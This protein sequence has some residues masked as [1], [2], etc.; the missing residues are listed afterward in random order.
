MMMKIL[1]RMFFVFTCILSITH[2]VPLDEFFPYGPTANDQMFPPNDDGSTDAL[3]L[4]RIFPYFNNNHRQIYLAN[5]G[6]FSFLGPVSQFVPTP[7]PLN[8]NRRVIAGFWSDIDTRGSIPSGNKVYYQIYANQSNTIVFGKATTYVQQ[9]FPG[10]RSFNPSMIITGTWYRVGAYSYQTN[11]ANTFQIVLATDE[12]RSFAFLLYHDLQWASPSTKSLLNVNSSSEIGG[13]AG[14]NAG[15][16][17][18]FEMLPYSRTSDV[19]RLVNIS[20]VNIPGLFVFRID[21]DTI[22]IGGCGNNSNLLFRPRRGSQLGFTPII[23]QG[24]CFTNTSKGDIKCRFG[25]SML[26]D[27]IVISEFQA[28]CLTPSVPLPTFINV[29]LSIDRGITYQLLPNTFTYTP[30]EYGLSSVDN[31]QVIILNRTDM[32]LTI[33][34]RLIL[35]WYLSET[36]MNNWPNNTI[37]FEIQMCI[38]TLN[39]SNGGITEGNS[40]VLQTNLTPTLGFQST[41]VIIS[42]IDNNQFSTV[43]FRIIARD[44]LTNTIYAGFNSEVIVLHDTN[45]DTSGYCQTWAQEQPLP[46]I[47]NENLLPCPLTIAQARVARCCYEPDPLCNENSY[48]S[49]INCNLHRGRSNRDELSAIAC[50]L[51]R[52]TNQWNAGTQCCYSS[53]GQLITHGTGAGTDNRYQPALS[54]IL[55]FFSDTLPFL[56]CCLLNSNE[57][58][59]T[60][61]FELRPP[62]R[63]SNSPNAWAGTWGDPHFTTLDGSAY[64]FNGYG[65]YIYLAITNVSTSIN[66]AFNPLIQTLIFNSQ[67]RTT[68]LSSFNDSATVIRG[69]AAKSNHSLAQRM[70]ITVSRRNILIIRRDNETLDLDTTNDDTIS[71]NN[72]IVLFFPEMT[73]ERNQTSGVLTLSWFIGV[74]IQ[75]TPIS[76]TDG[77]VLNIG[78]SV[79][80]LHQ[81]RTFGLLGLYDNNPNNDLRTPNGTIVGLPNTLT[82]QQIHQQFGQLWAIDPNDSLFYYEM[83]DSAINYANQNILYIPSFTLP[84]PSASQLNLTLSICNID[85]SLTNRSSWTTAQQTCFY[86]IAVTNDISL[87]RTSRIAAETVVQISIDQR[88]P[89]EFNSDLPLILIM[90]DSNSITINFTAVSPYTSYI[91]YNLIQGPSSASF[92]NQTALFYWEIPTLN[93]SETVIRVTAQDTQYQLLSTYELTIRVSNLD[94]DGGITQPSHGQITLISSIFI[95]MNI[96]MTFYFY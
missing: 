3:P 55:H 83:G 34:D 59:C 75:I 72:S 12:I 52:S 82:L 47:W 41:S 74:S 69:F 68:T 28:I 85:P 91:T 87:G 29:Y 38:V 66:A 54:P 42:S 25:E 70:S 93:N 27:A 9:Y 78:V 37:R 50:Y 17:I 7:F 65:E 89:P 20:N 88:Y 44:I 32:I 11:L 94:I 16:G 31:T 24:P 62:R 77:L 23:I 46:S 49:A 2:S 40:I 53:N 51:S 86:D 19:R 18:I 22:A 81:N 76:I 64:T 84:Q 5:N 79:A 10:E 26:V 45:I 33:G 30:V 6:L 4:P 92:D 36:T 95:V 35:G 63:G 80:G 14:F 61:Y 48:N 90:N 8:D 15:D 43:F 13:Q 56:A 67:I 57:E 58:N 96:V 60:R 21:S 71:T 39:E 73:L 1:I